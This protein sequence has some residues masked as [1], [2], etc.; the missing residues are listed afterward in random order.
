MVDIG[1]GELKFFYATRVLH[2]DEEKGPVVGVE[3]KQTHVDGE[4][5]S[6]ALFLAKLQAAVQALDLFWW[7]ARG[8]WADWEWYLVSKQ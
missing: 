8:C 1:S 7:A 6:P 4:K 5:P 2:P 3:L